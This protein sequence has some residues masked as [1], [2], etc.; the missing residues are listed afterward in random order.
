MELV[1]VVV[2]REKEKEKESKKG[3]GGE[4]EKLVGEGD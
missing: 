1:R 2:V 4:E 3:V